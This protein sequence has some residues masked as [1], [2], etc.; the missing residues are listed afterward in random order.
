[1]D[2]DQL[3]TFL[4]VNR[5]R[6]F[7]IAAK[8]LFLSQSTVSARIHSLEQQLGCPLFVRARNDI[9]LTP[10]GQRLLRH[11]EDILAAWNRARQDV[12]VNDEHQHALAVGA[13][14]SIWDI[15]LQSWLSRLKQQRADIAFH[16]E[17][18]DKD[19]LLRRL[20]ESTLDLAFSFEAPMVEKIIAEEIGKTAI[21]LV[22]SQENLH[23]DEAMQD[24]VSVDWGLSF[25]L[26][27]CRYF[28]EMPAPQIRLP[29]GRIAQEYILNCGGSAF[30][31]KATVIQEMAD[32]RLFKVAE[33]PEFERPVYALFCQQNYN[34]QL[35]EQILH[36][37]TV[38]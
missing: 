13:L 29:L 30:L 20:L 7:G 34:R 8:N 26:G 16:G 25:S 14:P 38:E 33:A 17:V 5:T 24:Y 2:S 22:S 23:L 10:A 28:P 15:S 9:Q 32:G 1:M 4:E 35:I 19:T 36:W 3:K 18:L 31:A 12:V 37:V 6:H 11:A 21:M 27:L